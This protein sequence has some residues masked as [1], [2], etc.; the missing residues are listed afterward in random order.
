MI[1]KKQAKLRKW[2]ESRKSRVTCWAWRQIY[3]IGIVKGRPT[4]PWLIQVQGDIIVL[5]I[6]LWRWKEGILKLWWQAITVHTET[7]QRRSNHNQISLSQHSGFDFPW[8]SLSGI[9]P[10]VPVPN[11]HHPSSNWR[12]GSCGTSPLYGKEDTLP[13]SYVKHAAL[14]L[15][16]KRNCK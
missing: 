2:L 8:C 12:W 4:K 11:P 3:R 16:W 10:K 6:R 1:R 13:V 9:F 5:R 15:T 7:G 14:F